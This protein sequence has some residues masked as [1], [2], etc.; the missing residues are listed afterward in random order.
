MEDSSK[1]RPSKLTPGHD[2][3]LPALQVACHAM[4]HV[5]IHMPWRSIRSFLLPRFFMLSYF[6]TISPFSPFTLKLELRQDLGLH[7]GERYRSKSTASASPH[8]QLCPIR[9]HSEASL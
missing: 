7:V 9:A 1:A 6:I 4:S 2:K 8:P 3:P 5:P